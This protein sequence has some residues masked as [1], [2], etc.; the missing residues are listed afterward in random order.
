MCRALQKALGQLRRLKSGSTLRKIADYEDEKA[1][2]NDILRRL[3][4]AWKAFDVR[5]IF[6]TWLLGDLPPRV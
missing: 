5:L 6:P 1:Q 3:D 4:N 2:L